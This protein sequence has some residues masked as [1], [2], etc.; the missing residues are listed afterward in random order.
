MSGNNLKEHA[1]LEQLIW[2]ILASI[3]PGQVTSYGQIARLAGQRDFQPQLAGRS[4][5][6]R[7]E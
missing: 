7:P 6:G 3:P 2:Q 5:K 1:E 4:W